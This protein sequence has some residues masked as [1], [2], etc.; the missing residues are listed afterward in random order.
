MP[1]PVGTAIGRAHVRMIGVIAIAMVSMVSFSL[2]AGASHSSGLEGKSAKQV[3]ALAAAAANAEGSVHLV[4]KP[5]FCCGDTNVFGTSG[6]LVTDAGQSEGMQSISSGGIYGHG[7]ILVVPGMAYVQGDAHWT[8]MIMT[9]PSSYAGKWLAMSPSTP[10]YSST[11]NGVTLSTLLSSEKP[12]G[13]LAVRPETAINGKKLIGLS[14]GIIPA[15][16][17][18]DVKGSAVIYISAVAPYLPVEAVY[19]ITENG[20]KTIATATFSKWGEPISVTAPASSVP[21]VG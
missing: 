9:L 17:P 21:L 10:N 19:H 3:W 13:R 20:R 5:F 7:T 8:S 14:G 1:R 2:H 4:V 15:D 18:A 12:A 6:V 16:W 11:V